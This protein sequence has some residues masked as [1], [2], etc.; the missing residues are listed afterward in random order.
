[1]SIFGFFNV[2]KDNALQKTSEIDH[3]TLL[4]YDNDFMRLNR[5]V[6]TICGNNN[7]NIGIGTTVVPASSLNSKLYVN[8]DTTLNGI[9]YSSN[10]VLDEGAYLHAD[11]I[12][13]D[14]NIQVTNVN[15]H[16]NVATELKVLSKSDL[17]GS[18]TFYS[19]NG[20]TVMS[21]DDITGNVTLEN[22]N[23]LML[24]N[25]DVFNTLMYE[26]G[27]NSWEF[28]L[29][30]NNNTFPQSLFENMP[31][32]DAEYNEYKNNIHSVME[33]IYTQPY[34]ERI[35]KHTNSFVDNI[36]ND[37][38]NNRIFS[39]ELSPAGLNFII[40]RK[41]YIETDKD[42]YELSFHHVNIINNGSLKIY[43]YLFIDSK[44]VET[45]HS[46][47]PSLI[48]QNNLKN[49]GLHK[50]EIICYYKT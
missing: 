14:C 25:I 43:S 8:G 3:T 7:T 49:A 47:Y 34:V 22:D 36:H 30:D 2:L 44:Y 35:F 42:N 17:Y 18:S 5:G 41:I 29:Y 39:T 13:I 48:I 50:I 32:T 12:V 6:L 4:D 26:N 19:N 38:R 16:S 40:Y 27:K 46:L 1:M 45:G 24:G 21:I 20:T 37:M 28:R 23:K 33:Y 9:L 11:Y 15:V 31:S 10:I